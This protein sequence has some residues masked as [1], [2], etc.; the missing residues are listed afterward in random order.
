MAAPAPNRAHRHARALSAGGAA[1]GVLALTG[2]WLALRGPHSSIQGASGGAELL[3]VFGLALALSC[4]L[5]ATA[6]FGAGLI[7]RLDGDRR[8]V[9]LKDPK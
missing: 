1:G 2:A 9:R 6:R 5:L 4:G 8:Q 3:L 7:R